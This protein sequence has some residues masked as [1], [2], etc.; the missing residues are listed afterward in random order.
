MNET[1]VIFSATIN[2]H[3]FLIVIF[4]I[5]NHIIATHSTKDIQCFFSFNHNFFNRQIAIHNILHCCFEATAIRFR[6]ILR[7]ENFT[8][9]TI[10]N[11]MF[12]YQRVRCSHQSMQ[13]LSHNKNN[14]ILINSIALGMKV[15]NKIYQCF[16]VWNVIFI[17]IF[18]MINF[19]G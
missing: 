11:G 3:I 9:N 8:E 10:G 2:C 5:F 4:Q 7:V 1:I 19:N 16:P 6:K 13:C 18:P 12:N 17:D 15:G 14:A